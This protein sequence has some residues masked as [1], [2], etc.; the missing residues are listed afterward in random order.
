[1]TVELFERDATDAERALVAWLTPVGYRTAIERKANDPLPFVLVTELTATEDCQ[2]MSAY[3]LMS[4]KILAASLAE[5]KTASQRVHRRMLVLA[6]DPLQDIVL[7]DTTVVSIEWLETVERPHPEYYS[8]TVK[9]RCAR[10][11]MGLPFTDIEE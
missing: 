11:R 3:P 4:V 10:Y 9:Q 8:D 6:R 5:V 2:Q 7:P 1:M